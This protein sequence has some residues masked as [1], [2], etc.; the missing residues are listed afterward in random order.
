M[1]LTIHIIHVR[2]N[3]RNAVDMASVKE[4]QIPKPTFLKLYYYENHFF[5]KFLFFIVIIKIVQMFERHNYPCL[6]K[7]YWIMRVCNFFH[8]CFKDLL[9]TYSQSFY[10][11]NVF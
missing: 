10:Q 3:L 9:N 7:K 11:L 6:F 2:V 4:L 8:K 5:L 1:F